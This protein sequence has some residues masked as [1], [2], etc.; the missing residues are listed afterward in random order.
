MHMKLIECDL[1]RVDLEY[2]HDIDCLSHDSTR[3][4]SSERCLTHRGIKFAFKV[5]G[6]YY[7]APR[8]WLDENKQWK[9]PI[10]ELANTGYRSCANGINVSLSCPDLGMI[11]EDVWLLAIPRDSRII[12]T[13]SDPSSP[14][15][16]VD[17][18]YPLFTIEKNHS[19]LGELVKIWRVMVNRMTFQPQPDLDEYPLVKQLLEQGI[20]RLEE[21][22]RET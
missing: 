11:H 13:C 1:V 18:A 3:L 20:E 2:C 6:N 16:R 5:F 10:V 14:N 17:K 21:I 19:L 8:Y 4:G 7:P 15:A 22:A 9:L 12:N